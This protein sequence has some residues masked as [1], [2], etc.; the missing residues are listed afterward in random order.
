MDVLGC[1][2]DNRLYPLYIGLPGTIGAA[3]GVGHP[4]TEHHAL[5]AK[6]TFSHS[7]EPPRW[8]NSHRGYPMIVD[9]KKH[10]P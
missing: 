8:Q 5:I 3:V 10:R 9:P 4:D 6:I 1:A 7:L 2:V